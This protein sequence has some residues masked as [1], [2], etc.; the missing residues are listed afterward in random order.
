MDLNKALLT[1]IKVGATIV[2]VLAVIYIAMHY[3]GVGFDFGY[4]VF[5]E[6]AI[7]A[8]PGRE[9]LVQVKE[10]M[11]AK[12]IGSMLEEKGLVRDANLFMLQLKLSAYSDKIKPGVYALRTSMTPKDMIVEMAPKEEQTEATESTEVAPASTE[13]S[14]DDLVAE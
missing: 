11:S 14:E 10:G 4:R 9:V 2:I 3:S 8:E 1:F 13:N 6:E 12:E 7:E 5:T